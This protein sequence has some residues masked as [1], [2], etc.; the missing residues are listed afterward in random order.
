MADKKRETVVD[1]AKFIDKGV[2]VKLSGGREGSWPQALCLHAHASCSDWE[3]EGIRPATE[4]GARRGAR[5][6]A[7][8]GT[9]RKHLCVPYSRLSRNGAASPA[10]H[11]RFD[12]MRRKLSLTLPGADPDDPLRV[13]DAKRMLGL[14]VL[15]GTAVM[16]VS[17]T[18]G[19]E[20]IA[21][22]FMVDAE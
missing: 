17:P 13:T 18:D 7:R 11:S 6:S 9:R 4:P 15:R 22:P 19:T 1:L 12:S 3:P 2:H 21:N 16:V 10:T 14:V 8:C 5:D 20:E